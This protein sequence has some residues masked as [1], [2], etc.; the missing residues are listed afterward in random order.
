[1]GDAPPV[2]G[3]EDRLVYHDHALTETAAVLAWC[4]RQGAED[5][6]VAGLCSGGYYALRSAAAGQPWSGVILINPG[7][8]G[9]GIDDKPYEAAADT[10]RYK[11]SVRSLESWKKLLRGQVDVGHLARMLEKRAAGLLG[12]QAKD[13]ARRI[14]IK[15]EDDLGT[16]LMQLARRRVAITF[17]FCDRE[18]GL[19]L[20]HERVGSTGPRLEARGALALRVIE[21]PDH[22]YTP[23]WS[24]EVLVEEI[25]AALRR[26]RR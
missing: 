17:L 1:M 25:A 20:F 12:A 23:R 7:E 16:D 26:R 11:Q 8:P 18:P 5:A 24:H 9:T 13:L 3:N 15:F 6:F 2:D 19:V 21:G 22:T 10:A 14:G 4:R